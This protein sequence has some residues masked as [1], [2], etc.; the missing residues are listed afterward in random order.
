MQSVRF[1]GVGVVL[2]LIDRLWC[3]SSCLGPALFEAIT[4]SDPVTSTGRVVLDGLGLKEGIFVL[5]NVVGKSDVLVMKLD[6]YL[7]VAT[8][9]LYTKQ[10]NKRRRK[11]SVEQVEYR[12]PIFVTDLSG[13]VRWQ[14]NGNPILFAGNI[15]DPPKDRVLGHCLPGYYQGPITDDASPEKSC[16][17]CPPGLFID[18]ELGEEKHSKSSCSACSPGFFQRSAGQRACELCKPG[19]F[20]D[21]AQAKECTMC[22]PGFNQS[23]DGSTKCNK[24]AT[25]AHSE[26]CST[27]TDSRHANNRLIVPACA[28]DLHGSV[29]A[30]RLLPVGAGE[31]RMRLMRCEGG[32][33]VPG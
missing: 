22:A 19:S 29:R 1:A 24:C 12:E 9:V 16:A 33:I 18:L 4:K 28:L 8:P 2:R 13:K 21:K 23:E 14:W 20:A 30:C 3:L 26:P 27:G 25:G 7:K 17:K 6:T 5:R 10:P 31:R 11:A 15:S 32:T